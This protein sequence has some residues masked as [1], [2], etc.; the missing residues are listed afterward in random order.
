VVA[1]EVALWLEENGITHAFGIIGGGN[2]VLWDAIHRHGKTKIVCCHHE[3][4]AVMASAYY[5]RASGKLAVSL[6]TT[7]AG[8]SNAVTGVLAAQMDSIPALVISGNEASK[9]MR[10]PTRVW[11]VQGY[12]S[13][14]LV[15]DITK[16]SFRAMHKD[17]VLPYLEDAYR[18]CLK[19]RQGA[20]WLDLPKDIQGA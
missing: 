6:V 9:Y 17:D 19:P 5:Y 15:E 4:A 11:G 3:Q 1:D 10:K 12:S 18:L 2:V 13:S 16:D 8:S 7:G 20:C 14:E